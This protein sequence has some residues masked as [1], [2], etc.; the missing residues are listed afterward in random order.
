TALTADGL[1]Y[2]KYVFKSHYMASPNLRWIFNRT[3][4][5]EI[6]KLKD[7]NGQY[8]WQDGLAGTPDSILE[9]PYLMSE[10]APSTMTT[11][12]YAGILGDFTWYWVA[13]SLRFELKRLDELFAM[14]NQVGFV[15]RLE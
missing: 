3:V 7:G 5:R 15:G 11:G 9:A 10:Y 4:V 2:A 12:L 1:I 13:E 8:I 14:T 6:R